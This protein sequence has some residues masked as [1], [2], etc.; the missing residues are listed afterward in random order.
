M[1]KQQTFQDKVMKAAT[2]SGKKCARC[3]SIKLPILYVRSEPSRHGSIRFSHRRV[4]VCKCN[5]KEVYA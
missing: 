3:G 2:Q 5:E 4:Q 1:A